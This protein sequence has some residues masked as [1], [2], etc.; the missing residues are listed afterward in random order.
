MSK[1]TPPPRILQFFALAALVAVLASTSAR[2]AS[3]WAGVS[4]NWT[5]T[6]SPGWNG[7]GV[8]GIGTAAELGS[9][10]TKTVTLKVAG[11]TGSLNYGGAGNTITTLTLT[12]GL[13][14]DNSSSPSTLSNT[15]TNTSANN[16]LSIAGGTITLANDLT[17]SN[18][19]SST[20]TSGSITISSTAPITGAGTMTFYNVSNSGSSGAISLNGQNTFTGSVVIQKGYVAFSAPTGG[21][22]GNSTNTI[23][24]GSSGNGDATL[25]NTSSGNSVSN[26]ISIAAGAG[27]L[28]LGS[29]SAVSDKETTYSGAVALNGNVTLA[30]AKTGTA[31]TV[32]SGNITSTG[33]LTVGGSTLTNTRTTLK[34]INTFTGDTRI[35]SGNLYLGAN[36]GADSQ[37]LAKSTVDLN[38]SDGGT[39]NFGTVTYNGT[40]TAIT[41]ATFG[42]LKGS[43][44][45]A[46]TNI[47]A[48]PAAVALT[49][50]NNNTDA[51]YSGNLTGS[52]SLIKVGTGAQTL[53][54][55]N[56]YIGATSVVGG[57]LAVNGNLATSSLTV[58]ANATLG[59]NGTI[60]G[61]T[62]IQGTH[63][64]GNSPGIQ[65]FA[66]NLT[67]SSGSS[68][69]WELSSSTTTNAPNPNA[70]FDTVVVAG[71]LSFNGI[72]NLNLSFSPVG[73]NVIWSDPFWQT[74]KTGTG[75][76]LIYDVAGATNNFSNLKLAASN[77]QDGAGNFFNSVLGSSTFS[78]Y[79]NG[80]DIF[81]NYTT[82]T[83]TTPEPSSGVA[84]AACALLGSVVFLV[85]RRNRWQREM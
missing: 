33:S 20:N 17:I 79:R 46:L 40:I 56:T 50:G 55:N 49:V 37:A 72:T 69:N 12:G 73:G 61:D 35:S 10:V 11:T 39:L 68:V 83:V 15:N 43:R 59:G 65:S 62:T 66:G 3:T 27:I 21:S 64:P 9:S 54:G 58:G 18:T 36:S 67:Y 24:L 81:L 71:N 80:S 84:M 5:D 75:G 13:A 4:G 52:G 47:S 30:S 53:F 78:L 45:L 28:T 57:T 34:G 31:S 7:T 2:A 42:G 85:R 48:S 6:G 1:S 82:S 14:F 51:S 44:D 22:F 23:T 26:N 74:S 16:R 41:S 70:I 60:T 76:W 19:G 63:N 38:T 77:W 25:V 8:P 32:Y 29:T